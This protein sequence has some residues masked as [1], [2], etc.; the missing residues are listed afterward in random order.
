VLS[1]KK[2]PPALSNIGII[3]LAG[4][5]IFVPTREQENGGQFEGQALL[6]A[7]GKHLVDGLSISGRI[8]IYNAIY[9][10]VS[11]GFNNVL[12]SSSIANCGQVKK[13]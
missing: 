9:I 11:K 7:D 3:I 1:K 5:R 6:Q 12:F 10:L 2:S 4:R 8:T 13:N